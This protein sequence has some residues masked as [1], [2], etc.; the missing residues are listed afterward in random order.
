M[1]KYLARP[2]NK[3]CADCKRPSP[4]WASMNLGVFVCIKCSGCHREIGV[5]VTKIKSVE[6]DLW[7]VKTLKDFAKINNEIANSYWEYGLKNYDYQRIRDNEYL[8]I[9]FIRDKYEYK[10]WVKPKVP[11]PMSLV[12]QGRDLIKEFESN[13]E[14]KQLYEKANYFEE[15]E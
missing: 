5:H 9:D 2:E 4:T 11:D 10:R 8:L 12:V 13:G 3:F 6:L 7:P 15:E 14:A 1:K